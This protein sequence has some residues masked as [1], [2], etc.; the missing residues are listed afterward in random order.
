MKYERTVA[1]TTLAIALAEAKAQCVVDHHDDDPL[2]EA[3]I[4]QATEYCER[5][6]GHHIGA[7]QWTLYGDGWN[8]ISQVPFYPLHS[9]TI[10]YDDIDGVEQT[11]AA[12]Q[13]YLDNKI[14]PALICPA[15]TAK[16]PELGP[17][18]NV[19]RVACST[20]HAKV[21]ETTRRAILLLVG[22]YYENREATSPV[23]L[24]NVPLAVEAHL[25]TD[26][27]VEV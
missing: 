8:E 14:Y 18:V 1:P 3:Y 11:L 23:N 27:L 16:W 21:L 2:I 20:G 12:D 26:R 19:V 9:V 15:E 25:D 17:G 10:Q 7:Q 5:Y 22:H 13:Y 24:H 6:L 4:H